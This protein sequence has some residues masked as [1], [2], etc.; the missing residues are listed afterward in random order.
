MASQSRPVVVAAMYAALYYHVIV[1]FRE[2]PKKQA[3]LMLQLRDV[4]MEPLKER[5]MPQ[6]PRRKKSSKFQQFFKSL[7]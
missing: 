7:V 2:G 6:P 5:F 1:L 3:Y 4:A